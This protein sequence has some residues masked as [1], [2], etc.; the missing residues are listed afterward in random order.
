MTLG[1]LFQETPAQATAV[2]VSALAYDDR[3]VG[4]GTV[5]FCVRGLTRDGHEFADR[6]VQ[7]GA[8]ALVGDHPRGTA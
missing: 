8:A 6:A 3:R 1:D 2:E 7:R 4:E 5:F